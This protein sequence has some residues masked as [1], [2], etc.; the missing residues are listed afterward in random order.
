[1]TTS[2]LIQELS[3]FDPDMEV[4]FYLDAM[5]EAVE[6]G[7]PDDSDIIDVSFA[8]IVE[9]GSISR[10]DAGKAAIVLKYKD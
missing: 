8:G 2:G 1:M 6:D 7:N 3:K 4:T 9:L 5:F 10:P